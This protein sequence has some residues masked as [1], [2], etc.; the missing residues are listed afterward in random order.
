MYAKLLFFYVNILKLEKLL[1]IIV[2]YFTKLVEQVSENRQKSCFSQK[3]F[4]PQIHV[5]RKEN[6][7]FTSDL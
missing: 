7:F 6:I 1:T 2:T 5:G 3:I 4:S